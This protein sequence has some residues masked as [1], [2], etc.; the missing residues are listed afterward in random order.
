MKENFDRKTGIGGSDA[1]KIYQGEW[2]D[3]YLEKIGEKEPTDLSDVL[4]V[5][6]GIHT[7]DFNIR[8]FE[9]QTGIKVVAQQVFIK[10]KKYPFMYCNID[11]V[12]NEKKALLECKHTNAFSNE[13]KTAE[14]YKAQLQHY[15]YVYGA[16][17][18]YLSIFFGNMKYGLVEVLPDK[19]FQEQLIAAEVL[20]WH[21]VETKTPPPDYVEFKNFDMKLKEFNDGRQIIPL[22]TRESAS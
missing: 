13:V 3:L 19:E 20:F 16:D 8:W 5:Q 1:T 6:M 22:L 21:L 17:K 14:K 18:M 12:L 2:Y 10:S 9:K 11:G 15:L 7:E 4:P